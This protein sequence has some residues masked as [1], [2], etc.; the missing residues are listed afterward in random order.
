MANIRV[1][2]FVFPACFIIEIVCAALGGKFCTPRGREHE[3]RPF[4][5]QTQ[6][7]TAID[8]SRLHRQGYGVGRGFQQKLYDSV[9][10]R[11]MAR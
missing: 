11:E 7:V 10:T 3:I 8:I 6:S 2:A 5:V 9:R 1:I 4:P